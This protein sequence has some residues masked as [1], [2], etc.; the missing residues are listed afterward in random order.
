VDGTD[1]FVFHAPYNKLVQKSFGRLLYQDMLSGVADA[2]A[3]EQWKSTPAKETYEDKN[4]E[5]AL[6]KASDAQYKQKVALAAEVSRQTGNTYTASVWMN[7]ANLVSELG[8]ALAGKRVVLFSYG[9][10]ALASMMSVIPHGAEV[11]ARFSLEKMQGVLRI[12]ERLQ[13]REKLSPADLNVALDAREASHG[14]VPF[15][16]TFLTDRMLPGTYFLAGISAN[17]ERFY[18]R[19]PLD[20]TQ[21]FNGPLQA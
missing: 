17:Y 8:A 10:G 2:A 18:R 9:S 13:K 11:N 7:M 21:V 4:L 15:T 20:A 3:I 14:P 5:T 1:Y 16:P 12:A 19:K 6:K